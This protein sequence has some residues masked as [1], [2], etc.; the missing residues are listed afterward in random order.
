MIDIVR[1]ISVQASAMGPISLIRCY[2]I[3]N[4]SSYFG[5]KT[6]AKMATSLV[7]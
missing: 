1:A 2:G 4:R 3:V 5:G 7:V 6:E